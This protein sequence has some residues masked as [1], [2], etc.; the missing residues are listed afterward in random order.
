MA[1]PKKNILLIMNNLNCGGAEKA[2]ISLLQ[3]FDYSLYTVELLLFKK[4]GLFLNQI[5]SQV[6]LLNEPPEFKYFDMA[7]SKAVFESLKKGRLD[8]VVNRI[9]AAYIFKTEKNSTVREQR[10]WKYLKNCLQPISKKYDAAIGFLEKNPNYFCVDK[11]TATVKIG[12]VHNDYQKLKMATSIDDYYFDKLHYIAT[13]SEECLASLQRSFPSITEKFMVIGN[14]SSPNV[15]K[16]LSNE[17]CEPL[18]DGL[19]FVTVGRLFE[20]KG[21]DLAILAAKIFKTTTSHDFRWYILGDGELKLPLEK[22]IKENGLQENFI[23]LG[24]VENPY[25]YVKQATIYIQ[26]SRFEGKSVAIDEAKILQKTILVTDF[27]SVKDQISSEINGYIVAMNPQ[28]IADGM[29][30]LIN[31]TDLQHKL[32]L[33]L[34]NETI[35]NEAEIEKIYALIP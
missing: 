27:S 20:Q 13:V 18:F 21:H 4:E 31:D 17:K 16:K 24:I 26:P 22:L 8:I 14:I 15:I 25:P 10:V 29:I 7:L 28:A 9:I 11:V 32:M 30:K 12:F 3:T 19:K 1:T 5:P 23:F 34:S 6:T 2:L 33:N 35:G